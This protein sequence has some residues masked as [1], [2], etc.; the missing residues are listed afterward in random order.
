MKKLAVIN[1]LRG[2]AILGVIYFHA[3]GVFINHPGSDIYY[4]GNIPIFPLTFLGHGW[5]GVDLFFILSGFVLYLPYATG[6]RE[7][8]TQKELWAFYKNRAERLLP[9]YYTVVII[10]V[11]FIVRW[12]NV[13][14]WVFWR[15]MLL[16]FTVTF[17]FTKGSFIPQCNYVL[18][19]LGIEVLFS[20][21]FPFIIW[22]MVKRGVIKTCLLVFY[23]SFIVRM[24][25]C[26]YPEYNVAPHLNMI[27]D[28]LFG[29]LDDFIAGMLLCHWFITGWKRAWFE[30]YSV[31][32]FFGAM[33]IIT[34]GCYFSDYISMPVPILPS[35]FEPII[36]TVFQLG[37]GLLILSLL[38]MKQNALS[39]LFT[40]K[41]LQLTGMMCY[42][43][44]VW[45]AN[46][47]MVFLYRDYTV[48]HI[49][50]YCLFLFALSFLTYRYIE[51]GNK[52]LEEILPK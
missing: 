27:K 14:E 28:S 26:L 17:N 8:K 2:Y 41:F 6:R 22:A 39:Y 9:L 31:G 20:V 1:G 12:S 4:I 38:H 48:M 46:M 10:S 50:S 35:Y 30:K 52:K 5:L 44:Y 42:S 25:S 32:A 7:L 24:V 21:V 34:L 40:N 16:M 36:N 23:F 15:E 43:L 47:Q 49:T 3:I 11:V 18:W 45:H 19:S 51:F 29:R 37:F 33:V 13:H